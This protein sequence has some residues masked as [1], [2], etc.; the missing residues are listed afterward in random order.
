MERELVMPFARRVEVHAG[1]VVNHFRR[2]S[3]GPPRRTS[4]RERYRA[5]QT[6][7][8]SQKHGVTAASRRA[9]AHPL[10]AGSG[11]RRTVCILE[12]R[13]APPPPR[14]RVPPKTQT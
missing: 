12:I 1:K 7:R 2:F 8:E 11:G 10:R 13:G 3:H 4:Y 9:A 14:T 5:R 6:S